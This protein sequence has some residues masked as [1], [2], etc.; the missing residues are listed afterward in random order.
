MRISVSRYYGWMKRFCPWL[1]TREWQRDTRFHLN[2]PLV[3]PST[4]WRWK[5]R[6]MM[7]TGIVVRMTTAL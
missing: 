1:K 3:M 7:K 4:I 6:V 5:I 2:T